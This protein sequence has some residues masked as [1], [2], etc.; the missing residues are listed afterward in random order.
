[1]DSAT[2]K[3]AEVVAQLQQH[4]PAIAHVVPMGVRVVIVVALGMDLALYAVLVRV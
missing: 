2:E 1:M 3:R 4:L